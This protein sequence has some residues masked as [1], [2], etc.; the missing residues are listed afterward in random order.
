VVG[1]NEGISKVTVDLKK[2]GAAAEAAKKETEQIE[3]E[4]A[5]DQD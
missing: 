5:L 2:T 3:G 1:T 4:E